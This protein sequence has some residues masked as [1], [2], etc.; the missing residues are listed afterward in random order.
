MNAAVDQQGGQQ[1][2]TRDYRA[3]AADEELR[4]YGR[5]VEEFYVYQD[6][7][8]GELLRPQRFLFGIDGL[9]ADA[10]RRRLVAF[11]QL[12]D[13]VEHGSRRGHEDHHLHILGETVEDVFF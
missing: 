4:R 1:G 12:G 13:L 8:L 2:I 6:E 9:D 7:L 5:V 3:E 10:V 11:E